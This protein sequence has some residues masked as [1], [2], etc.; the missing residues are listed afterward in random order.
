MVKSKSSTKKEVG[1]KK[2][3]LHLILFIVLGLFFLSLINYNGN[4]IT[5]SAVNIENSIRGALDIFGQILSPLFEAVGSGE[6]GGIFSRIVIFILLFVVIK[7]ISG[8]FKLFRKRDEES[9]ER[10]ANI[11]IGIIAFAGAMAIPATALSALG[12]AV[13]LGIYILAVFGLIYIIWKS[14]RGEENKIIYFFK[15]AFSLT[16]IVAIEAINEE[17]NLDS[18]TGIAASISGIV[19]VI[20]I[21]TLA[22]FFIWYL[23]FQTIRGGRGE[24]LPDTG[25]I[26]DVGGFYGGIAGG[27]AKGVGKGASA[28]GKGIRDK[29]KN[30]KWWRRGQNQPQQTGSVD[31]GHGQQQ[32][33]ATQQQARV[34]QLSAQWHQ[35][36]KDAISTLNNLL[37]NSGRNLNEKD[38]WRAFIR[39]LDH[40]ANNLPQAFQNIKPINLLNLNQIRKDTNDHAMKCLLP[41]PKT[42]NPP[43]KDPAQNIYRQRAKDFLNKEALKLLQALEVQIP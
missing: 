5:G 19:Q 42:R 25:R 10:N 24:G 11:T 29:W 34:Q 38:A 13:L 4:I 40:I 7:S 14:S 20:G 8:I 39:Y 23:F 31:I 2:E 22:C 43:S 27:A 17:F 12:G 33:Q 15:G 26:K 6:H 41:N 30:R 32:I 3:Y 9:G 21:A 28:L 16:G 35:E 1:F 18:L 37:G 36:I